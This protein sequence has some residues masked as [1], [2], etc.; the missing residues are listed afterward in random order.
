[1]G[2]VL[3]RG[4]TRRFQSQLKVPCSPLHRCHCRAPSAAL[5]G[6]WT[7]S[8]V[9]SVICPVCKSPAERSPAGRWAKHSAFTSESARDADDQPRL[10]PLTNGCHPVLPAGELPSKTPSYI[11]FLLWFSRYIVTKGI[12][13][14]LSC[15]PETAPHL[16]KHKEK[17]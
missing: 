5:S 15:V 4:A 11:I 6:H 13:K 12:P 3:L 17:S 8:R 14:S 1:M 9:C 16:P 7:L 2:T 10:P